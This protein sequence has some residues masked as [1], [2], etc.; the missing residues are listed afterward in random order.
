ML[1]VFSGYIALHLTEVMGAT[2]APA[3]LVLGGMKLAT[4]VFDAVLISL[5]E[6]FPGRILVRGSTAATACL[7]PLLLLAPWPVAK[8][9]PLLLIRLVLLGWHQVLPGEAYASMPGRSATVT[10]LPSAG[11]LLGGGMAWAVGWLA[12]AVGLG[13]AMWVLVLG[14]VS[15]PTFVRCTGHGVE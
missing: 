9:V 1:D 5:L 2:P 14:R 10:G 7:Y 3:G 15:L 11:T 12:G 13:T 8:I 4:L 6:R